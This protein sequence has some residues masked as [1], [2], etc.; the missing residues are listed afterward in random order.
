LKEWLKRV[1]KNH[2]NGTPWKPTQH[3]RICS[4]HFAEDDFSPN[5]TLKEDAVPTLFPTYPSHLQC[6][7]V[8]KGREPVK[9]QAAEPEDKTFV[10]KMRIGQELED[11]NYAWG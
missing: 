1:R 7:P 9:R 2:K 4:I 3:S 5:K 11:H 8:K 10:K 6:Q